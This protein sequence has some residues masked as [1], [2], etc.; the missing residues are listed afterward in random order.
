[1][2][3]TIPDPRQPS[4]ATRYRLQDTILAAFSVF[5]MQNPSFL[6]YQR[7]LHSRC[8][9]DNAQTLFGLDSLPTP[10]Q[11]RNILDGVPAAY[12][13][14]VFHQIYPALQTQGYLK[15]YQVLDDNLLVALDGTDYYHS[16]K[17]SCDYC[18]TRQHKNGKISY[19]HRAILPIITAPGQATVLSLPPEFI[20]PQDGSEKQDCEQNAAKRWLKKQHSWFESQAVT[21]LGDDLYSRQPMCQT[22]LDQGYNFILVCLVASH[23][24]LYDWLSYLETNGEMQTLSQRRWKGGGYEIWSYRYLNRVPLRAEQPALEVNWCEVRIEREQD[25]QLLYQNSWI[26]NHELTA[27]RV[28]EVV[29]AGR[30]RWKTENENHNILKQRGYHLEHNFGHGHRHLAA[31]LISLN[32]LAFLFHTV[33]QLVDQHYQEVRQQRGIRQGFFQ[34]LVSLTKYLVFESWTHLLKFML[35]EA[36]PTL[37]TNTS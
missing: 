14:S 32:V 20:T 33:L 1:M 18:S 21:V 22:C 29:A 31:T 11:I 17:I 13:D 6:E 16:E 12:F 27:E 26:T 3:P 36:S 8:G 7:Q 2:I 25:G 15:S 10:A 37:K 28:I 35:G 34:D 9:R 4:N 30:S 24:S 19:Y 5:F 23:P